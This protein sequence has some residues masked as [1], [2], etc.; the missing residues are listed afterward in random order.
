MAD[1]EDNKEW[2]RVL[3][4]PENLIISD[5]LISRIDPYNLGDIENEVHVN[6]VCTFVF[7][8]YELSGDVLGF[9]NSEGHRT[10]TFSTS[11]KE[12]SKL[13]NSAQLQSFSMSVSGDE[14][15]TLQKE[16]IEKL[17]F[18]VDVQSANVALVTISFSEV[19]Q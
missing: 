2:G 5:S 16:T 15:V 1:D 13:M 12:A 3:S 19:A 8:G 7:A 4:N 11:V 17:N 9:S 6:P 14:I 10:Y 18:N